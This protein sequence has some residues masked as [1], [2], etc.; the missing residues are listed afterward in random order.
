[1]RSFELTFNDLNSEKQEEMLESIKESIIEAW[2]EENKDWEKIDWYV[3][4]K[5]WQE[6]YCRTYAIEHEY[7]NGLDEKSDEFQSYDWE[8]AL[9]QEA[10]KEAEQACW[11]GV[12]N[13]EIEVEL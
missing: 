4:P 2:K 13:M 11:D 7:W 12:H 1:M 8:Y 6:A 9:E 5:T 3:K 10:E